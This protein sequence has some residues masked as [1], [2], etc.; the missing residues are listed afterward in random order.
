MFD[1]QV[2]PSLTLAPKFSSK[3]AQPKWQVALS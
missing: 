2:N 3:L 1:F